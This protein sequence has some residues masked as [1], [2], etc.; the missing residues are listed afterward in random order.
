MGLGSSGFD[1]WECS[2]FTPDPFPYHISYCGD[3]DVAGGRKP[4]SHYRSVLWNNSKLEMVV[5]P[6]QGRPGN[7]HAFDEAVAVWG[8]E[9]TRVSWTWP[10]ADGQPLTVRV[11]TQYPAAMIFLNGVKVAG[12]NPVG[13]AQMF[14]WNQAVTYAP[15]ELLAVPCMPDGTLL[16]GVANVSLRTAGPPA[17]LSL[18]ADYVKLPADRRHLAYVT[19]TVVDAHGTPVPT[20][21]GLPG[22]YQYGLPAVDIAVT[23]VAT[24]AGAGHLYAVGTGDPVDANPTVGA[25]SRRAYRGV[26]VAVVQPGGPPGTEPAPGVVVVTASAAG[27]PD[28][29]IDIHIE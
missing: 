5:S 21:S 18:S 10:G 24:P 16:H 26:V 25:G 22:E 9:D 6:P 12:P 20:A 27:M 15:G 3:V 14:T 2:G 1:T 23:T 17:K 4:Q 29:T 11:Y 8:Y 19:V 13:K 28:A 7:P